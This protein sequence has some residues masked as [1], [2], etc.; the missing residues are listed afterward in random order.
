MALTFS[1]S[2][3][4][5]G[6]MRIAYDLNQAAGEG[7]RGLALTVVRESGDAFVAGPSDFFSGP[8]NTFIDWAA[9]V[10]NVYN[11]VGDGHPFALI[12]P[13]VAGGQFAASFPTHSFTLSMGYLTLDGSQAAILDDGYIS[14][15]FTGTTASWFRVG[16]DTLRGGAI[17][18]NLA[19]NSSG[20]GLV[21]INPIPEPM[22]LGLLGLG[23]LFVR[24][25]R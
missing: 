24:R 7:L 5:D 12:M 17:G 14:V 16:L 10:D 19:V 22:T 25:R 8:F 15:T 6:A 20:L 18:D 3:A 23:A 4:G 9:D 13:D 11:V 2:D 21:Q 1:L